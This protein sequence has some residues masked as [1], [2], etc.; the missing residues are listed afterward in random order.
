MGGSALESANQRLSNQANG[1]SAL[2]GAS[3]ASA[4]A[5][6]SPIHGGKRAPLVGGSKL[7]MANLRTGANNSN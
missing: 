3:M 6:R 7:Q 5:E 4:I 2:G 1:G